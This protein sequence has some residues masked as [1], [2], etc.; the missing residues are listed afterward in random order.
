MGLTYSLKSKVL[1]ILE[2]KKYFSHSGKA[3]RQGGG[4]QRGT[5]FDQCL[6]SRVFQ[7]RGR[8]GSGTGYRVGFGS[9]RSDAIGYFRV[10][11]LVSGIFRYFGYF[12]YFR[13]FLGIFG[14]FRYVG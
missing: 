10:S 3:A 7:Y 4:Y 12:G 13:V 5:I 6:A 9:G 11:L 2:F 8:V 14:Y 1:K